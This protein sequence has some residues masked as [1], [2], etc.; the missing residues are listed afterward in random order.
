M[1]QSHS[2]APEGSPLE[3]SS[4]GS[5]RT[6]VVETILGVVGAVG[7]TAQLEEG[8]RL[9]SRILEREL[10]FPIEKISV[11]STYLHRICLADLPDEEEA[12][13]IEAWQRMLARREAAHPVHL[14]GGRI[15]FPI[16]R[17]G[18]ALG[19][20]KVR[21]AQAISHIDSAVVEAVAS[22]SAELLAKASLRE[23]LRRSR[24]R[25]AT[26]RTKHKVMTQ[27]EEK[28]REALSGIS[29]GL[30]GWAK[31]VGDPDLRR[32]LLGLA[33]FAR[34]TNREVSRD[35]LALAL[36]NRE[37]RQIGSA[38]R[39]LSRRFSLITGVR[40]RTHIPK[41][42]SL[43]TSK[44]D[45]L[46]R[47]ALEGLLEAE[48]SGRAETVTLTLAESREGLTLRM[49]DDGL[50]MTR[51]LAEPSGRF[52]VML[53]RF[54][55]MLDAIGGGVKVQDASPRGV[56]IQVRL[57]ADAKAPKPSHLALVR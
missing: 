20:L 54:Q 17:K 52:L 6:A 13:A 48:S 44:S 41:D 30:E 46:Y 51:R 55:D 36:G 16:L 24:S 11:S 31:E 29:I 1:S 23:E 42:V 4:A 5:E 22:G 49:R 33:G 7:A 39:S 3:G 18:A 21:P 27:L 35:A 15:L 47:I 32:R 56:V 2:A 28:A 9:L 45:A 43:T 8:T 38:I 19:S 50:G 53:R 25:L 14:D 40:V 37:N 57:G 10:G 34:A 12:A 26:A